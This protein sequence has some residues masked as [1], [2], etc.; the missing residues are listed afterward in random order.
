MNPAR[1][2]MATRPTWRAAR[3]DVRSRE[4]ISLRTTSSPPRLGMRAN[5][6]Q[7]SL[8]IVVNLFVGGMVGLERTVVPLIG[9]EEFQLSSTTLITSF[10]VSFGLVKAFANLISGQLADR[11]G[12]KRILVLG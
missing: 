12:R 9:S 1:C 7:F 6:A 11:F 4:V 2:R 5:L 3:T 10:I 8:L